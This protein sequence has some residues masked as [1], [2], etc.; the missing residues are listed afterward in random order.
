MVNMTNR[1]GEIIKEVLI[2]IGVL[3]LLIIGGA[4]VPNIFGAL[5]RGGFTKR[6]YDKK[7]VRTFH[8]LKERN[9]IK[10][11]ENKNETFTVEL[12]KNGKRKVLEY[13]LDKLKIGPMKK[14]DGKWRFIMFDIPNKHKVRSNVLREK[15]KELGFYQYQKSVWIHPYPIENEMELISQVFEV[16]PFIKLG[17]I[18]SLDNNYKLKKKFRLL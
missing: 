13:D 18:S 17:E 6:K 11:K 9:L 4:L 2:G 3:G 7:F 5:N 12:S 15:L 14:W 16:R 8:Y 1:R 10:V